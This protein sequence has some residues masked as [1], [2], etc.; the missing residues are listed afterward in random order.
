[1]SGLPLPTGIP[2]IA[3][4]RASGEDGERKEKGRNLVF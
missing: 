2:L 1:M 3:A 4:V